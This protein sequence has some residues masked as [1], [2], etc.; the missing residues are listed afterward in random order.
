MYKSLM[1]VSVPVKVVLPS[2][3]FIHNYY[4][5]RRHFLV[6]EIALQ[7]RKNENGAGGA[8]DNEFLDED[9]EHSNRLNHVYQG[10]LRESGS[11]L[12]PRG[13]AAAAAASDV[14][15]V[16]DSHGWYRWTTTANGLILGGLLLVTGTA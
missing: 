13:N 5:A 4:N 9:R 10:S 7:E 2:P 16:S 3:Y 14:Q 15:T 6:A 12:Q 8:S 11:T 1:V